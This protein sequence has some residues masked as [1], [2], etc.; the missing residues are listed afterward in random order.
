MAPRSGIYCILHIKSGKRYIGSSV[1]ARHRIVAHRYMLRW[2]KHHS[3]QL[4]RTWDRDGEGAFSFAMIEYCDK[5]KLLARE[6]IWIDAL[7]TSDD[8]FGYNICKVTGTRE[9]VPQPITVGIKLRAAH[10]GKPKSPEH[11]AK[12]AAALLGKKRTEEHRA[13]ISA[14]VSAAMADPERRARQS[15]YGRMM[16]P[17]MRGKTHPPETLAKMRASHAQRPRGPNGKYLKSEGRI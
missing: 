15:E 3:P 8:R 16:T 5:D 1:D 17:H 12:I 14:A 13:K 11:R 10:K 7:Q 2:G 9:G 6:Q 4:Q